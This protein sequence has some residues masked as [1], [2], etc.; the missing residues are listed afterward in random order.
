MPYRQK[1]EKYQ[2]DTTTNLNIF[3]FAISIPKPIMQKPGKPSSF[4]DNNVTNVIAQETQFSTYAFE[5][6]QMRETGLV[7]C[8]TFVKK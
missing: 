8:F 4:K 3:G 1:D 5:K 6:D 2:Q 7:F